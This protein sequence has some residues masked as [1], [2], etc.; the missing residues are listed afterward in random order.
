MKN[1]KI[2][3]LAIYLPQYHPIKENDEWWGKGF[4]EWRNVA[5]AKPRFPL[6]YQPHIPADLGFYDLRLPD[7]RNEQAAL[8]QK[9]GINGFCYYHYWFN[10]KLLLEKPLQEILKLK[11]PDFPFM[12]CWA[13]ENWSRTWDGLEKKILIRQEYSIVDDLNHIRYLID[14]FKDPRYIKVDGK[15]V[16]CIYNSTELP[17]IDETIRLWRDE[18]RK[19]NLE[20][21]ICRF[22][23]KG[24]TG[25]KYMKNCFDAAI[26]FQPDF[27][28]LNNRIIIPK[29]I[30]HISKVL[31]GKN[32]IP[33]I[34]SYK[35]LIKLSLHSLQP[36]YKRYPCVTP[37]WDNS[38][39][40]RDSLI[41]HGSS[42]E[43]FKKWFASVYNRF[44]PFSEDEN[45][46]FINA[47]NEWAEGNH[48]EPDL[49]Y[50]LQYLEAVKEVIDSE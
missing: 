18:A 24:R 28:L 10:G 44:I 30:N 32:I 38:A 48:L 14:I 37:S 31:F 12:L 8:A 17:N 9:Y 20:L 15:P 39:R 49:K 1:K 16:F 25:I 5:K 27:S 6:H 33:L 11:E 47:W 22:E 26:E 43:L 50:G 46:I 40:K 35:N 23:G 3:T 41:F 34:T 13:N 21:Y 42:P 7:V 4:T 36:K 45:F 29:M 19:H 2:R